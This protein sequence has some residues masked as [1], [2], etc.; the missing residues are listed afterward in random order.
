M[1]FY[2]LD[3]RRRI[4]NTNVLAYTSVQMYNL[5][6]SQQPPTESHGRL[7]IPKGAALSQNSISLEIE[8][9]LL[10]DDGPPEKTFGFGTGAPGARSRLPMSFQVDHQ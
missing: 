5:G 8:A 10:I 7:R 6:I 9:S 4:I 2:V 1:T 3:A